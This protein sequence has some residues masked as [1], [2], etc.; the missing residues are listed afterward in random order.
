MIIAAG[1]EYQGTQYCGWQKQSH[2]PSVQ[3]CLESALSQ[4]ADTP[5]T[6]FCAGRTDTGVHAKGQVIHF[7]TNVERPERAWTRGVN[8]LLPKDIA[9]Q[10]VKTMPSDFHARFSAVSRQY[11]YVIVNT[12]YR[13]G[14]LSNRVTWEAQSLDAELMHI[15][16]QSLLGEQDFSTFQAA[17]CQSTSS[18]RC[19]FSVNVI[20]QDDCVIV[21]ITANAFLHHMVRN[22]VGSLMSVGLKKKGVDWIAYLLREKNRCLAAPTAPAEGLYLTQVSYPEQYALPLPKALG[23]FNL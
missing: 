2:S 8:T 7:E 16:A 18:F 10:W 1:I 15:A 12:P 22:I 21:D 6:V 14:I 13:P 11:H 20:R 9:V 17:S 5:I 23:L 19:V 4:I 3:A